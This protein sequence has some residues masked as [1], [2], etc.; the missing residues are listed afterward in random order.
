MAKN[1]DDI[2]LRLNLDVWEDTISDG[3]NIAP[4]TQISSEDLAKPNGNGVTINA[5]D[6][7]DCNDIFS[8]ALNCY[9]PSRKVTVTEKV[10]ITGKA[11]ATGVTGTKNTIAQ[12]IKK[13]KNVKVSLKMENNDKWSEYDAYF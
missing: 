13:S 6:K 1:I 8:S 2:K 5:D 11:T 3:K 12:K 9:E 7:N 10:P 4:V